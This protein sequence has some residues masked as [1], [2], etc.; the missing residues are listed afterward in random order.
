[1][2]SFSP[3]LAMLP[4]LLAKLRA[5]LMLW[6]AW[7]SA[8]VSAVEAPAHRFAQPAASHATPAPAAG[9][10]Q[11]TF[12]L[13]VVLGAIFAAAWLLRRFR[14]VGAGKTSAEAAI[15]VL[16]E[17]AVGPRER[18][19]LLQ[20]GHERV[21]VGVAAG[22]VRPLHVMDGGAETGVAREFAR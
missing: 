3:W 8:A 13:I 6:V 7:I 11:V 12:S 18:V 16:A 2:A 20:V 17:R 22:S 14:A 5:A 10:A 21:L 19:V 4:A 9:L 1:M 15:V